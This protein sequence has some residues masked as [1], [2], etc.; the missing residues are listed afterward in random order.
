MYSVR[1]RP[2]KRRWRSVPFV[3]GHCAR[4]V[5][6]ASRN[7][8]D[9]LGRHVLVADLVG[10]DGLIL[11]HDGRVGFSREARKA[12]THTPLCVVAISGAMLRG[13]FRWPVLG[14]DHHKH[15]PTL[16][17]SFASTISFNKFLNRELPGFQLKMMRRGISNKWL[18]TLLSNKSVVKER[19]KLFFYNTERVQFVRRHPFCKSHFY[20][21]F[22]MPRVCI[23][24]VLGL[25]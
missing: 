2:P 8:R 9:N 18:G 10:V 6:R 3:D 1:S 5:R 14:R 17:L 25:R 11:A 7:V 15:V 16:V 19:R 21:F 23:L 12:G 4:H 13:T 22:A 24:S 20:V